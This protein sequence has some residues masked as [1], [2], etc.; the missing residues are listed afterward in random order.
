[1]DV[2]PVPLM[3]FG[4]IDFRHNPYM[5]EEINKEGDRSDPVG[6]II[7]KETDLFM[8][9]YGLYGSFNT[10]FDIRQKKRVREVFKLRVKEFMGIIKVGNAP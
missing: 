2:E 3:P 4:N 1:M 9:L 7:S 5:F 8:L 6:I 10:F